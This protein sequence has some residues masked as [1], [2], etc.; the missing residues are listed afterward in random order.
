MKFSEAKP[1]S[2]GELA[3]YFDT[4]LL[5]VTGLDGAESPWEAADRAAATG[6]WLSPLEQAFGGRTVTMPAF[7]YLPDDGSAALLL[8]GICERM[9]GAGFRYVAVVCGTA[10]MLSKPEAADLLFGPA[11]ADE[12]PDPGRLRLAMTGLWRRDAGKEA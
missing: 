6:E 5:P 10:G 8:N 1:E 12:R 11:A 2:W 4:C 7:H 9:K 3:P